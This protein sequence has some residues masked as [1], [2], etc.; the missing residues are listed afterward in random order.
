MCVVH[1]LNGNRTGLLACMHV[2]VFM[3]ISAAKQTVKKKSTLGCV[4]VL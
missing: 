4:H 1:R 3:A 2:C